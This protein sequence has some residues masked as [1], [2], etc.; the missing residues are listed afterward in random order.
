MSR[1]RLI[2]LIVGVAII[3]LVG[4]VNL[5]VGQTLVKAYQARRMNRFVE[6]Y[7][8]DEPGEQYLALFEKAKDFRREIGVEAVDHQGFVGGAG[9][10]MGLLLFCWLIDRHRLVKKMAA[11][12]ERGAKAPE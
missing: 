1:T 11:A 2:L 7:Q 6:E 4:A 10:T 5:V 12:G 8:R 9:M 3:F